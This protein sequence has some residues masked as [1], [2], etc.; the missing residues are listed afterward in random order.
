LS[1]H[2]DDGV[3]A[4][5]PASVI[6]RKRVLM[7]N[8]KSESGADGSVVLVSSRSNLKLNKVTTYLLAMSEL[9]PGK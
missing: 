9:L 7:N 4:G 3:N 8:V 5:A 6:S 2:Q 1:T